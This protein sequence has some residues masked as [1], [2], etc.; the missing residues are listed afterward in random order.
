M[1]EHM[2]NPKTS[3]KPRTSSV[4]AGQRSIDTL[5]GDI[6]IPKRKMSPESKILYQSED[7]S[8]GWIKG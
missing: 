8:Q 7:G 4:K 1:E 3:K 5:I 2:K 6:N